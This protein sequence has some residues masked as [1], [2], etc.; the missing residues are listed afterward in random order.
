MHLQLHLH[1]FYVIKRN[2]TAIWSDKTNCNARCKGGIFASIL[3]IRTVCKNENL[4]LSSCFS[5]CACVCVC[6]LQG[7]VLRWWC[8]THV[9]GRRSRGSGAHTNI[10][11]LD[12][13]TLLPTGSLNTQR[14]T[15]YRHVKYI[16]L[17]V[18]QHLCCA[19]TCPVYITGCKAIF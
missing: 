9:G 12:H 3:N 8:Y 10:L 11:L 17:L 1:Y 16:S 2:P 18:Q 6:V 4:A 7:C 13:C 14:N 15:I 5:T 19:N